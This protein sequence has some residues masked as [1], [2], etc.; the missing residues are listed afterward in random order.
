MPVAILKSRYE[1]IDKDIVSLFELMNYKK[2]LILLFFLLVAVKALLALF[3]QV[4]VA[5]S[6]DYSYSMIARS[7]YNEGNFFLH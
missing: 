2:G 1:T 6:D 3:I 5:F 4:P 7:F